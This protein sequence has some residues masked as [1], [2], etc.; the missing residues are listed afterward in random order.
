MA[1]AKQF[2]SKK[3]RSSP[4]SNH[5]IP[6]LYIFDNNIVPITKDLKPSARGKLEIT[7]V[8]I[9]YLRRGQLRVYRLSRGFA[10][11]DAGTKHQPPRSLR[12]RANY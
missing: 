7:D 2:R 4:K 1:A 11:L 9:E 12:L 3:S 5:A 10:W 6:G 8:G